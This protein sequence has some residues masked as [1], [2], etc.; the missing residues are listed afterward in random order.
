MFGRS[1][2]N[3]PGDRPAGPRSARTAPRRMLEDLIGVGIVGRSRGR[4]IPRPAP[5]PHAQTRV[6]IDTVARRWSLENGRTDREA[7]PERVPSLVAPSKDRS[8][9]PG[10]TAWPGAAITPCRF[11]ARCDRRRAPTSQN[12]VA[13]GG[14][15]RAPGRAGDDVGLLVRDDVGGHRQFTGAGSFY[16]APVYPRS[17]KGFRYLRGGTE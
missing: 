1:Q 16:A 12:R 7:A 5:R 6:G 11:G 3:G 4:A 9:A 8:G 10:R 15:G 13:A 17:D 2:D 14:G